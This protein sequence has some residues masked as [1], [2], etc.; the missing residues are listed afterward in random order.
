MSYPKAFV[1]WNG[2]IRTAT[3]WGLYAQGSGAVVDGQPVDM[4]E[5]AVSIY[6]PE[7]TLLPE[8]PNPRYKSFIIPITDVMSINWECLQFFKDRV[9]AQWWIAQGVKCHVD[10]FGADAKQANLDKQLGKTP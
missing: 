4:P 5:L 6:C 8:F 1:K 3:V 7:G 10:G 9:T 2:G